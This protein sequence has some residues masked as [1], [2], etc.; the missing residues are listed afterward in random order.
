MPAIT[1]RT[2]QVVLKEEHQQQ[3]PIHLE[4]CVE[5][6]APGYMSKG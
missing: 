3:I 2:F 6:T 1:R 4:K 5:N